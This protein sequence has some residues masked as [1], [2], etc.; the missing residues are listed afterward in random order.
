MN[1]IEFSAIRRTMSLPK[2]S[3][4]NQNK[5]IYLTI[6]ITCLTIASALML[7]W[8]T[9]PGVAEARRYRN[10]KTPVAD[11]TQTNTTTTTATGTTSTSTTGTTTTTGTG[12]TTVTQP[13][14]SSTTTPTTTPT[15]T[16]LPFAS[17]LVGY[18][19]L[20]GNALGALGKDNGTSVG[21]VSY[22][23]GK[24]GQ[25]AHFDGKSYVEIADQNYFSP[26]T[27]G[28]KMTTSFW[29]KPDTYTFTGEPA[30]PGYYANFLGKSDWDKGHE[31]KFRLYSD[32]AFDGVSRARRLSFYAFNAT[33][34]L[35]AG[36]YMSNACP[37]GAW[38][39]V[40]GVIDGLSTKLYVNGTLIDTDPLSGYN[41]IMSNTAAPLRLGTA[42]KSSFL[43][44]SLSNVM[45]YNRPLT[46]TEVTQLY[47]TDLSK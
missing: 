17:S 42:D 28:Q 16:P 30:G 39:H 11:S 26:S 36:S 22:A 27:F 7:T 10:T 9:T 47:Q 12:T 31:W 29:F 20:N 5:K 40:V 44:G 34:G 6:G 43:K 1:I 37:L 21:N 25:A 14:T 3:P 13:T 46:A 15:A 35:G 41:I 2:I 4:L 33:G 19:K 8:T 32:G 38:T 18:W 23:P 45:I 24:F